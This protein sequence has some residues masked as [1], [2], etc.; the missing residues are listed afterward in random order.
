MINNVLEESTIKCQIE[1]YRAMF[2]S[3]IQT[4]ETYSDLSHL[5]IMI[6]DYEGANIILVE[7]IEEYPDDEYILCNYSSVLIEQQDYVLAR[8]HLETAVNNNSNFA[9]VYNNLGYLSF[10]ESRYEDALLNY[11]HSIHLDSENPLAY[12]NR[13]VLL[14]E[15]FN[16]QQTGLQDLQISQSFGD[17]DAVLY[18]MKERT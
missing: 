13:G 3:N 17:L 5:L 4:D 9:M 14:Y 15:I 1:E 10:L 7:G 11:N 18:L 6:D 2:R 16:Q 8:Q 12:Y